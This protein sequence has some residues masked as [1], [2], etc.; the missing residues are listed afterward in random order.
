MAAPAGFDARRLDTV[1]VEVSAI[2]SGEAML[3]G[4]SQPDMTQGH[5]EEAADADSVESLGDAGDV[6]SRRQF[7]SKNIKRAAYIA[8]IIW[9]LSARTALAV[10]GLTAGPSD[11]E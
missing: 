2:D 3:S 6:K 8:P 11:P 10:T 7:L 1:R 5:P 9:S 4:E